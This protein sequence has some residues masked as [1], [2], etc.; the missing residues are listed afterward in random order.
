MS[1][2]TKLEGSKDNNSLN[3]EKDDTSIYSDAF[4]NSLEITQLIQKELEKEKEKEKISKDKDLITK[5]ENEPKN[6]NQ[7]DPNILP[8]NKINSENRRTSFLSID[9]TKSSLYIKKKLSEFE[10]YKSKYS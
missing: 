5:S 8:K 6:K 4:S 2:F 7:V 1:S 10:K 3:Q 9:S